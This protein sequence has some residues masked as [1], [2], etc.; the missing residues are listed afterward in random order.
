[1]YG[2]NLAAGPAILWENEAWTVPVKA[3]V[4]LLLKIGPQ[5]IQVGLG[6]RYRAEPPDNGPEGL[7]ARMV[8]TF[9]FP[10]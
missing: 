6:V 2:W 8:L 3:Q 9:L 1:M 7:G 4:I 5:I 10:K